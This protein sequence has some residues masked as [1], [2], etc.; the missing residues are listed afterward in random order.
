MKTK[1]LS[2]TE[3]NQKIVDRFTEL[4]IEMNQCCEETPEHFDT[5]S[6]INGEMQGIQFVTDLLSETKFF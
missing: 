3:T 6:R 4:V 2:L 1:T 5:I